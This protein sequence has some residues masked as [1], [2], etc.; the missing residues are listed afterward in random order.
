[1]KSRSVPPG[2]SWNAL[3]PAKYEILPFLI[4][5]DGQWSP[6]A[7]SPVPGGNPGIDVVFPVLHG[8]FG[9]DG[10]IQGLFEMAGLPYV[11]AGVMASSVAMDKE[12]TKRVCRAQGVPVTDYVVVYRGAIDVDSILAKL[13]LPVFVKPANM[14]SSVGVAKAKTREEL[15]A[16]LEDA[17]RYDRKGDCGRRRQWSRVRVLGDG[18]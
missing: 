2:P 7:I 1:M 9:E 3:D 15:Q 11:S 8:T 10:T 17:A 4:S 5:P 12:M 14:G 13:P 18:Q 16:A 6:R